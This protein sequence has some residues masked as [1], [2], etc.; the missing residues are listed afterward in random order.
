VTSI[1]DPQGYEVDVLRR[2][3]SFRDMSVLD[4]GCGD[5]RTARYIARSAASVIGLDP[6]AERIGSARHTDDEKGSCPVDFRCEDVVAID[7]PD[8]SFDAVIF[9][10]SL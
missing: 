10:R 7:F 5:G 8:G 9:T 2:L 1:V 3:V 6:D 4:V